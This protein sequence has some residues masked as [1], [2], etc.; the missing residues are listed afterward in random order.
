MLSELKLQDWGREETYLVVLEMKTWWRTGRLVTFFLCF[1]LCSCFSLIGFF[2]SVL[3]SACVSFSCGLLFLLVFSVLYLLLRLCFCHWSL[4]QCSLCIICVSSMSGRLCFS[5]VFSF[6]RLLC[7]CLFFPSSFLL[8]CSACFVPLLCSVRGFSLFCSFSP[9]VLWFSRFA[10]SPL[11]FL[12]FVL[13]SSSP[14]LLEAFLSLAYS[15]R[16]PYI[17]VTYCIVGSWGVEEDEQLVWKRR[18]C[19]YVGLV[20]EVWIFRN[21]AP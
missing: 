18:R 2:L 19:F 3:C 7:V 16:M 8:V 5:W 17:S 12:F 4:V 20:T 9:F 13:S 1:H 15:Q 14:F 11:V 6:V 10:L 21:Q